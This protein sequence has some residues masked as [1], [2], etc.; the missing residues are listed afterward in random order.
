MLEQVARGDCERFIGEDIQV[1]TGC[2]MVAPTLRRPP[3]TRPPIALPELVPPR[4]IP[5]FAITVMNLGRLW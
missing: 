5:P 4:R 2:T 3:L 1:V